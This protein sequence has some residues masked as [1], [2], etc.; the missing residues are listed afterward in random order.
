MDDDEEEDAWPDFS[1]DP[2]I[3]EAWTTT[4]LRCR[5]P[6]CKKVNYL[7]LGDLNDL[8]APDI[9]VLECWSCGKKAWILDAE[10]AACMGQGDSIDD[11]YSEKGE[12]KP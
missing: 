8:S 12:E 4:T 10:T 6:H 11:F 7:N 1:K 3:E 2:R 9:E 5:C